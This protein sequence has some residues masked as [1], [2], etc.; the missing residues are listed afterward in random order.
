MHPLILAVLLSSTASP[1][2]RATVS[3]DQ[4]QAMIG[5]VAPQVEQ[6]TGRRF[7]ELP[8]VHI[9]GRE[10]LRA[11]SHERFRLLRDGAPP[12]TIDAALDRFDELLDDAVAVYSGHDE[13]FYLLH[14]G[15]DMVFD[16]WHLQ[17]DMLAP[18]IECV[19]VHELT[20]ALQHQ[21]SPLF[22]GWGVE[23]PVLMKQLLEGHATMVQRRVCQERGLGVANRLLEEV[24]GTG[25][26]ASLGWDHGLPGGIGQARLAL[27]A[28]EAEGGRQA[29][30]E[31]LTPEA[32]NSGQARAAAE[33]VMPSGWTDGAVLRDAA[34]QLIGD[35][36]LQ[37][38]P[39]TLQPSG[40]ARFARLPPEDHP[41]P[42]AVGGL[43][44][45]IASAEYM[46][47]ELL[48]AAWRFES[49]QV[50]AEL[51]RTHRAWMDEQLEA[52]RFPGY[53]GSLAPRIDGLSVKHPAKMMERYGLDAL[54]LL[55]SGATELGPKEVW[56]ADGGVVVVAGASRYI[57]VTP[58][59]LARRAI[60]LTEHFRQAEGDRAA[61]AGDAM[62]ALESPPAPAPIPELP[63]AWTWRVDRARGLLIDQRGREAIAELELAMAEWPGV[64]DASLAPMAYVVSVG[65]GDLARADR[66]AAALPDPDEV[67]AFFR[68]EH[69]RL[70]AAHGRAADA[71]RLR[72]ATCERAPD[73]PG[74][75]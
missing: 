48:L 5:A 15:V 26:P 60:A 50:A 55:G 32:L 71:E 75:Q 42:P 17:P 11:M 65:A 68:L 9:I 24:M 57:A 1:M 29:V 25:V 18:V 40:L 14:E 34:A 54:V 53:A 6:A 20:H 4:M 44:L 41:W 33:G 30:W 67:E 2:E 51:V 49:E 56:V 3:V 36:D 47:A 66:F 45:A 10:G 52:G 16:T 58:R 69:A 64:Y 19:V 43:A 38:S 35:P 37:I 74:C 72:A 12:E 22:S 46:P 39:G 7:V 13:T 23:D 59:A 62:A 21:H 31:L 28:A 70:L 63:P 27:A 73:E 8:E 61:A